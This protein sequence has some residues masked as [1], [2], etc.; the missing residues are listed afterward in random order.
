M[1]NC[2]TYMLFI[3]LILS[4]LAAIADTESEIK[5]SLDY[6]E[7]VWNEG[8]LEAIRGHYHSDFISYSESAELD[9]RQRIEDL[10]VIMEEGKDRGVLDFS[11]VQIRALGDDHALVWGRTH[12]RFKDGTELGGRF[13][14]VYEK[15]PF[16]WKELF[17]HN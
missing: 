8:D 15:T 14:S 13:S 17:S 2:S 5:A 3:V 9:L 12:L 11:E 10:S 4:P 6:L 1:K 7:Q 16:G